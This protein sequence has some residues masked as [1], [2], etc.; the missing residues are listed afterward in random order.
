MQ[1][2]IICS[3]I[4]LLGVVI[5]N[6]TSRAT[7]RKELEKLKWQLIHQDENTLKD[8]VAHAVGCAVEFAKTDHPSHQREAAKQLAAVMVKTNDKLIKELYDCVVSG[9]RNRILQLSKEI[10]DQSVYRSQAPIE[11]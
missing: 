1:T 4:A 7:A 2:E 3:L 5:S 6:F 10:A 11:K 9:Q 8:E